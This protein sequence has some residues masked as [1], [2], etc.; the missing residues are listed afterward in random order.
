MAYATT[1]ELFARY[2]SLA[3]LNTTQATAELDAASNWVDGHCNRT[4]TA[5]GSATVRYFAAKDLYELDLGQWEISTTDGV[6]IA[7]DDG[8]NTFGSTISS[9][10]YILEPRNAPF[11]SPDARPFTSIRRV[12]GLWPYAVTRS[13]YQEQVKITAKYGWPAVPETVKRVTLA[14]VN[15]AYENPTG[16]RSEAIDGYSVSYQSAGGQTVGV[17]PT[18]VSQLGPYARGW[19]A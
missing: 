10:E 13:T 14:L 9:S 6:M 11:A 15:L 18:V 7:V 4:F 12:S 2:P 3:T 8:T 19:A 17:P 5:E 1:G 16:V